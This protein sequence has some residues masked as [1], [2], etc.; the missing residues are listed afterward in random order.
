MPAEALSEATLQARRN[1][2]LCI[3]FALVLTTAQVVWAD[4]PRLWF[5][6]VLKADSP[7]VLIWAASAAYAVPWFLVQ[8]EI[9]RA[10]V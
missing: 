9:G 5:Q 10:H 6:G 7:I 8:L 2:V 1:A 4:A 3:P